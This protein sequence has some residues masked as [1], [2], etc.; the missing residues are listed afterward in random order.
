MQFRKKL[1]EEAMKS[2]FEGSSKILDDILNSQRPSNDKSGVVYRPKYSS[3][4]IQVGNKKIYVVALKSPVKK[5][6]RKKSIPNSHD[7]NRINV[8]PKKPMTNGYQ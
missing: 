5:E 2:K 6:E 4:T 3:F 7:K 8:M 1:D